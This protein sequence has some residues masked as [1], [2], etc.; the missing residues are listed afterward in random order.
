MTKPF[1]FPIDPKALLS[2]TLVDQMTTLEFGACMRLLCR[3]WIDGFLP[4]DKEQLRRL[5]RLDTTEIDLAW[6]SICKFFPVSVGDQ[7]KRVNTYADKKRKD[8]TNKMTERS[9]QAYIASKVR[10]S[11][12]T[13]NTDS[14]ADSNAESNAESN[15]IIKDRVKDKIKIKTKLPSFILDEIGEIVFCYIWENWPKRKDGKYSR[16][17]KTQGFNNY[18]QILETGLVT[19]YQLLLSCEWYSREYPIAK[20]GYIKRVSTFFKEDGLWAECVEM[21]Q[22]KYLENILSSSEKDLIEHTIAMKKALGKVG[23]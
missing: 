9:A 13:I 16:G 1:W 15:A 14:I 7:N 22:K 8:I 6:V 11:N 20:E 19:P 17:E 23:V 10:W 5:S 18:K 21:I 12:V 4:N 3:Q 2:D